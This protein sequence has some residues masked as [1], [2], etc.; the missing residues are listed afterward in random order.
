MNLSEYRQSDSEQKRTGDL[1]E[2][3][4]RIC[5]DEKRVLDIGARDGHF[6]LL[7]A[8]LFG[9]VTALDLEQ[10]TI[11]H[12]K[13]TC[14]QGNITK[15]DIEDNTFD[16]V[17]CAEV[18]EHIPPHLLDK[19]TSELIRVSK[20]FLLIGVPYKQD[21]RVGRTTCYSCGRKNPPWGHVNSFDEI[22]LKRLFPKCTIN[23]VSFVGETDARTNFMSA[24][25]MDLAGNPYG[26]Y[27][28]EEECVYCGKKLIIPPERTVPQKLFTRAAFYVRNFQ[29]PFIKAH[30]NWIHILFHKTM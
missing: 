26:T 19:A 17:F 25:L 13:V 10:P 24:F 27:E 5:G 15:L 30:P 6:S 14:V 7:L 16:L 1:M 4:R 12:R 22:R 3:S 2:H 9:A 29:K 18:L 23:E 21:I 11:A 8:D 28:Q 20:E